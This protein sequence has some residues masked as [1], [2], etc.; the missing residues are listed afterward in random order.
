MIDL[1]IRLTDEQEKVIEAIRERMFQSMNVQM[2]RT[3]AV[4]SCIEAGCR[5]MMSKISVLKAT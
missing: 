4:K 5:E 2:T 1:H 3:S